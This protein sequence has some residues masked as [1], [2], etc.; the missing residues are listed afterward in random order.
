MEKIIAVWGAD[1]RHADMKFWQFLFEQV[2]DSDF[3][4]GRDFDQ[5]KGKFEVSLYFILDNV[6]KIL[7]GR[8]T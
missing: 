3:L 6:P 1:K 4:R 7:N 2:R 5:R 8:Y